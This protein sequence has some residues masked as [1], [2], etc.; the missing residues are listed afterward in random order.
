MLIA[1]H[2]LLWRLLPKGEGG[3]KEGPQWK[4]MFEAGFSVTKIY[5]QPHTEGKGQ[6]LWKHLTSRKL[7]GRLNFKKCFFLVR[8]RW[9]SWI[10]AVRGSWRRSRNAERRRRRNGWNRRARNRSRRRSRGTCMRAHQTSVVQR[11]SLRLAHAGVKIVSCVRTYACEKEILR[12]R[13]FDRK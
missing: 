10:D 2:A 3:M 11:R 13:Q 6:K 12:F 4:K 1:H 9:W 7:R 5:P 8:R